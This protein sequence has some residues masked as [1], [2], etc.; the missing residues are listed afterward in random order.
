[1]NSRER[2]SSERPPYM[3]LFW[4]DYHKKTRHLKR[5]AEHGAYLL[6][7]GEAW[8]QAGSLPDDDALLAGWADCTLEEWASMKATIMAFFRD[9]AGPVGPQSCAR[10]TGHLRSHGP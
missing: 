2:N 8:E 5:A 7:I 10:G 9:A 3:K 6:L 1:M 4:G